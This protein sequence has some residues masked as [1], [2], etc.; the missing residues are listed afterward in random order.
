MFFSLEVYQILT[1]KEKKILKP[2]C[3][4]IQD[5]IREFLDKRL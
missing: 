3:L 2:Q 4:I 1:R 5:I